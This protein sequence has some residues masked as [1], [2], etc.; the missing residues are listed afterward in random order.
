M[1]SYLSAL[2]E[3]ISEANKARD[4]LAIDVVS[5]LLELSLE[6]ESA[7][8]Y[9]LEYEYCIEFYLDRFDASDIEDYLKNK[10]AS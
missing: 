9:W 6:P 3:I 1:Q 5:T 4:N 10:A 8:E 2:A 7:L